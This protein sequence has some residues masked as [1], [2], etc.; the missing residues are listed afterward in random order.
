MRLPFGESVPL[1]APLRYCRWCCTAATFFSCASCQL[2]ICDQSGALASTLFLA[3]LAIVGAVALPVKAEPAP[4]TGS[5][6]SLAPQTRGRRRTP[7]CC[8]RTARTAGVYVRHRRPHAC[9]RRWRRPHPVNVGLDRV[10]F[11]RATHNGLQ[12]WNA[13]RPGRTNVEPGRAGAQGR[14]RARGRGRRAHRLTDTDRER[15][16]CTSHMRGANASDKARLC[17]AGQPSP[18]VRPRRRDA[19]SPADPC[20][21]RCA[22]L[23]RSV[24]PGCPR[25]RQPTVRD[26]AHDVRAA[27]C[28]SAATRGPSR[29]LRRG[30]A[31]GMEL[32]A[33]GI[34]R[35]CFAHLAQARGS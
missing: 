31:T 9:L 8:T 34:G 1:L 18:C 16:C 22:Q 11:A 30:R 5:R 27:K 3:L 6:R 15:G 24:A 25:Q 7:R 13:T 4:R 19:L 2:R 26:R 35:P 12:K 29:R 32:S 10:H 14:K 23:P 21:P 28:P 33:R 20:V 17:R